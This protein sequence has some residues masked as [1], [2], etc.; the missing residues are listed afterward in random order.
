MR[1]KWR[2]SVSGA[3][4]RTPLGKVIDTVRV[5]RSYGKARTEGE[6]FLLLHPF[7][8]DRRIPGY[9]N[10][11][12]RPSSAADFELPAGTCPFPGESVSEIRV[13]AV[14]RLSEALEEASLGRWWKCLIPG[15]KLVFDIGGTMPPADG[16]RSL[17]SVHLEGHGFREVALPP[18]VEF[19][20]CR[21]IV[22]SK[23]MPERKGASEDDWEKRRRV[24]PETL[25]LAWRREHIL[26]QVA[27]EAEEWFFRD[28][29]VLSCGCGS[30]ELETLMG[31]RGHDIT[32]LDISPVAL[33]I[34]EGH[35]KESALAG[36]RFVLGSG[37]RLPFLD[38]EFDSVLCTEV[39]E[40]VAPALAYRI[41]A[42]IRRVLGSGGRLLLTVPCKFAYSDP[43][44][45]QV[46][47]KSGLAEMLDRAG[48][49]ID[50][51]DHEERRDSYHKHDMLV[52][53]ATVSPDRSIAKPLRICA[54]GS[55]RENGFAHLG[56]HWDGQRRAFRAD[57]HHSTL[58]DIGVDSDPGSV[59][60]QLLDSEPDVVWMGLMQAI[61][62]LLSMRSD[63]EAMRKR[64][65]KVMM[66]FC[67][68]R[69]PER[70]P[71]GDVLDVLFV[72]NGGQG[73]EYRHAWGVDQVHYMPQACSP[74]F[75]R[76]LDLP[77]V[78]DIGHA[79]TLTR[80]Y[81]DKRS[82]LLGL[83]ARNY[84][85]EVRGTTRNDIANFYAQSKIVFGSKLDQERYLYTS[86]RLFVALGCGAFYLC[87]WFPGIER[88]VSNHEHL[89]WFQGEAEMLELAGHYMK[90]PEERL[91]IRMNAER[92]AHAGHTYQH[93]IRNM[94]G[95]LSG[96]SSGFEGFL[97][98]VSER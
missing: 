58:V 16:F 88:L 66:W 43:G 53:R 98:T 46:F 6:G 8:G 21:D 37:E 33:G 55:Y 45:V 27:L 78:F 14:D 19:G 94:V 68:L 64:G 22:F 82:Q 38:G 41:L 67:D 34:A 74:A 24:R 73:D 85:V 15:G 29:R 35:R 10:F 76:R 71:L 47:D 87:E 81:H 89:V 75:M 31:Q 60:R 40:H 63:I 93:R 77:E 96:R 92:W 84:G 25:T 90:R 12:D 20:E 26:H 59:R 86:N 48:F 62:I 51:L 50:R 44:H 7:C 97:G 5:R 39:L 11:D 42:E 65:T 72:S 2:K 1:A 9:V 83:L 54:L 18:L 4:R 91:R 57:G 36:M 95:I 52:A 17:Y 56:F 32:G 79:G 3:L 61:P 13:T 70:L 80:G 69:S 23:V 49:E 28:R 30:A